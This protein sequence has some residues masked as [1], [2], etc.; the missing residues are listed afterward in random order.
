MMALPRPPTE[1]IHSQHIPGR[2]PDLPGSLKA[3]TPARE[4]RIR[5]HARPSTARRDLLLLAGGTAIFALLSVRLELS[6][7]LIAWTRPHERYQVDEL[8]GVLLFIACGLA[9]Y[10]WRR[11]AEVREELALRRDVERRLREALAQN[12]KQAMAAV[13]KQEE[14]RRELARELHDHLGQYVNAAKIDAVTLRDGGHEKPVCTAADAIVKSLDR[15]RAHFARNRRMALAQCQDGRQPSIA[16][17]TEARRAK[18]NSVHSD[19]D[20][21]RLVGRRRL[22]RYQR[23]IGTVLVGWVAQSGE[24]DTPPTF[25]RAAAYGHQT[26]R[27]LVAAWHGLRVSPFLILGGRASV[28]AQARRRQLLLLLPRQRLRIVLE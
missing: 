23:R 8:P 11:V 22:R 13:S 28:I 26:H 14:D 16:H 4:D 17:P 1:E 6:E 27:P 15:A 2:T 25:P 20:G 12:R 19:R 9:W 7:H 3:S 10:A 24:R 21:Q 5:S 18:C